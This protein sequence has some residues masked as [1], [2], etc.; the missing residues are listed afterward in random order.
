MWLASP[1]LVSLWNLHLET[2]SGLHDDQG[3]SEAIYH[4]YCTP[5]KRVWITL[6]PAQLPSDACLI[7]FSVSAVFVKSPNG[8]EVWF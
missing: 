8:P 5:L 7:H 1:R 6:P 2:K 3:G 4:L